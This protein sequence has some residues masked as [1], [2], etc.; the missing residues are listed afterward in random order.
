MHSASSTLTP[1]TGGALSGELGGEAIDGVRVRLPRFLFF[2]RNLSLCITFFPR[3]G[4]G[5]SINFMNVDGG[6]MEGKRNGGFFFFFLALF[7]FI[8]I[9]RELIIWG[10]PGGE[11]ERSAGVRTGIRTRPR[12]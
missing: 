4:G 1:R 8:F 2:L 9:R 3:G 6:K 7:Y 5:V 10:I 12:S 11:L